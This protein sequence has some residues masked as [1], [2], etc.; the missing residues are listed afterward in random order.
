MKASLF[1]SA[2]ALAFVFIVQPVRA[3]EPHPAATSPEMQALVAQLLQAV[4]A[5]QAEPAPVPA[6]A[7]AA[8]AAPVAK[9]IPRVASSLQTGRL[10]TGSLR[11]SSLAPSASLGG[12]GT[13]GGVARLNDE[14]WRLLFPIKQP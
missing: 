13:T 3:D 14:D 1:F 5:A 6:A 8:A 10:V 12:R 4:N 11:T 7:P 9:V 2:V